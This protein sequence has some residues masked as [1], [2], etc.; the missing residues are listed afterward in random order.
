MKP[1]RV[2]KVKRNNGTAGPHRQIISYGLIRMSFVLSCLS[3]NDVCNVYPIPVLS[4]SAAP[5]WLWSARLAGRSAAVISG[6][7]AVVTFALF[8]PHSLLWG[9]RELVI[10]TDKEKMPRGHDSQKTD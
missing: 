1:A 7:I 2:T 10:T 4:I 3:R 5:P 8:L 9:I 6:A